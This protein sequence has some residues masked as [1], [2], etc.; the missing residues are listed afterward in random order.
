MR[1]GDVEY[2]EGNW[3]LC[4][5][6]RLCSYRDE[7]RKRIMFHRCKRLMNSNIGTSMSCTGHHAFYTNA[8]ELQ[9]CHFVQPRGAQSAT[10]W[11]VYQELFGCKF[12]RW[13]PLSRLS[14]QF[15]NRAHSLFGLRSKGSSRSSIG[16]KRISPWHTQLATFGTIGL[17]DLLAAISRPNLSS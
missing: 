5:H 3:H 17:S 16:R 2:Q 9:A 1:A 12:C 11:I 6:S 15:T 13:D 4:S 8:L 10:A 7:L 14:L